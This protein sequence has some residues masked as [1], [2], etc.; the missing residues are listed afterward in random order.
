M[1]VKKTPKKHVKIWRGMI[2]L[3]FLS[4][5][6]CKAGCLIDDGGTKGMRGMHTIPRRLVHAALYDPVALQPGDM[7]DYLQDWGG[8]AGS[9]YRARRRS[10]IGYTPACLPPGGGELWAG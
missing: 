7:Q 8:M 5:R 1:A 9:H 6:I 10:K 2:G 3:G 4:S